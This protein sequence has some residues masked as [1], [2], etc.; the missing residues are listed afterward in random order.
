MGNASGEI[1]YRESSFNTHLHIGDLPYIEL[2]EQLRGVD[3]RNNKHTTKWS[4]GRND[5]IDFPIRLVGED[6]MYREHLVMILRDMGNET[7]EEKGEI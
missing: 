3:T 7:G 6:A 1:V 2:M 4:V 5:P